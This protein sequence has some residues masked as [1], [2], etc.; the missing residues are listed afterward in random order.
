MSRHRL[1]YSPRRQHVP[2]YFKVSFVL[3]VLALIGLIITR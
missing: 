1:H 2:G 3:A